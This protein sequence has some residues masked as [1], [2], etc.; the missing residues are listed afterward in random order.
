VPRWKCCIG[1]CAAL[2]FFV[3]AF[4]FGGKPKHFVPAGEASKML[5]KDVC[6]SAHIYEVVRLADG[7]RFL[8]VCAPE[9]PD[10]SC[11]FTIV[12]FAAD[13]DTVGDLAAYRDRNVDIRGLVRPMNGRAGIVLS[14]VR[15][16]SGGPPRF[17]PNPMLLR[18]FNADAERPPVSDPNLRTHGR[19]RTFMN[20]RDQETRPAK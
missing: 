19:G 7:T 8:D 3:P 10:A 5:N 9:T 4:C 6:V 18:G 15:Q 20:S 13:R 1:W 16:F 17:R 11:R 2:I 12:S 14:H